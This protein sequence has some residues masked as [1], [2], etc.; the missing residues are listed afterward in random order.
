MRDW[1]AV[2]LL[3]IFLATLAG[4]SIFHLFGTT[5]EAV[6]SFNPILDP[7]PMPKTC[8]EKKAYWQ[9]RQFDC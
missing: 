3:F 8:D 4:V 1:V 2:L 6:A 7:W 5:P 9:N